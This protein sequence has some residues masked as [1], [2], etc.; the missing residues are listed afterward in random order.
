MVMENELMVRKERKP[1]TAAEIVAQVKL[2][3]EVMEA[4]MVKD[5]HYG[6]IP[7]TAKPTLYKPG[8]EKLLSTFHIGVDPEGRIT[9]LST[10]D[11]IRY[12]VLVQGYRQMTGDPLGTG[13]GECSSNEE[14]YKWRKPVCDEEF[15]ETVSDRKRIVWKK[16]EGKA[17]QQK[18]VRMNPI[19]IANTI[20]KMAKKRSLVDMTLTVLS[21]SDIF[22]QDLED[23][24]DGMELGANG[25]QPIK[26]PQKKTSPQPEGKD[27]PK[28]ESAMIIVKNVT[29][30]TKKKDGTVMKS[31]LYII[32]SD[33]G[34]EYRTFSESLMKIA[35]KEKGMGMALLVEFEKG[36]Y[37]NTIIEDG[38][39]YVDQPPGDGENAQ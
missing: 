33:T 22:D 17:Y 31:P 29:T 32:T 27:K 26:E 14:K 30:Q 38:L 1:L 2:I 15:D 9:D 19:D 20:L 37:G 10:E 6:K 11:E 7:G 21:A 28:P 8:A 12:R 3:Q 16:A 35:N 25:K 39:S 18:Q 13:L 5:V 36:P 24:P 23:L 4:V 34:I